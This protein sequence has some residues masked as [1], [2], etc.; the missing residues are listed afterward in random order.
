MKQFLYQKKAWKPDAH[1]TLLKLPLNR[2]RIAHVA[3]YP[4]RKQ[5]CSKRHLSSNCPPC[6]LTTQNRTFLVIQGEIFSRNY[7][8]EAVFNVARKHHV[9]GA[10]YYALCKQQKKKTPSSSRCSRRIAKRKPWCEYSN[11]KYAVIDLFFFFSF[12]F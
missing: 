4:S 11:Y 7:L 9:R 1:Q 3:I 2:G 12:F 6:N 5:H 8:A 10:F